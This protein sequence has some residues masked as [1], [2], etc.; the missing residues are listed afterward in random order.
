VRIEISGCGIATGKPVFS[1]NLT[2]ASG[3]FVSE[4]VIN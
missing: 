3:E 1:E 4:Q 2:L